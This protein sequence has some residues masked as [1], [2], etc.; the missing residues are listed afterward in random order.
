MNLWH[1]T[2]TTVK[3]NNNIFAK[4]VRDVLLSYQSPGSISDQFVGDVLVDRNVVTSPASNSDDSDFSIRQDIPTWKRPDDGPVVILVLESPH[5]DEFVDVKGPAKGVTGENIRALFGDACSGIHQWLSD[6][7]HP[8]ILVN[9]IQYQCS[10]GYPTKCFRDRVFS[11]IWKQGG[12]SD[13][14]CRIQALYREGDVIINA[15]TAGKRTPKNWRVVTD[16]LK[17]VNLIHAKVEHPSNWARR[18]NTAT[19]NDGSPNYGWKAQ[20]RA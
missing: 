15:C 20:R 4:T 5:I 16:A 8:L 19:K 3:M 1:F 6:G 13:F 7:A 9:A 14:T 18:K 10:L 2:T 11:E 17:E 12:K